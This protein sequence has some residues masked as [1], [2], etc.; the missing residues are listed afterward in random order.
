[1]SHF[2]IGIDV[3][4]PHCVRCLCYYSAS[5]YMYMTKRHWILQFLALETM[6][7][8]SCSAVR[9]IWMPPWPLKGSMITRSRKSTFHRN[10][11]MYVAWKRKYIT[12]VTIQHLWNE[13]IKNTWRNIISFSYQKKGNNSK[14]WCW[15]NIEE[16]WYNLMEKLFSNINSLKAMGMKFCYIPSQTANFVWWDW[17]VIY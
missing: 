16:L 12:L 6:C 5:L 4:I 2:I 13:K 15:R 7:W 3:S 11:K 9:S 10:Q 17:K 8:A 14:I 1:L